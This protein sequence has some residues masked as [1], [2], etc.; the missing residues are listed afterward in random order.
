MKRI[1]SDAILFN[2][3]PSPTEREAERADYVLQRLGEFGYQD[4]AL[5]EFGNVTVVVPAR[6]DTDEH[7]LMFSDIRCEDYSPVESMT[8]LETDRVRGKGIAESSVA[9]AALLVLGEYLVRNEIQYD[10]NVVLLFT[11]FDPGERE[12]QP[13]E[14]F[15]QGWKARLRSAAHVRGLELGRV[16][17]RPLGTCKLSVKV[18][19]EERPVAAGQPAPSAIWVLASI[20]SRLGSIR[21]DAENSTFLNVSRLEAGVG[22]GWY[23]S[24]GVLELE[25]FSP[26]PATLDVARKAVEATIASVAQETGA[27]VD[28]SVK[29]FLPAGDSGI[30]QGLATV[31]R[32]IYERLH[33]KPRPVSLPG[34]ASL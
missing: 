21:W 25:V 18:H 13:L 19:T 1:V 2:E 14:Q 5:D 34:Y 15:L 23:P 26:S 10:R 7:V 3:I 11:S 28:T 31:V 8:K 22:F 33:I 12:T 9:T 27:T 24:E 30:N 17:D 32:E 6:E 20:A 16:E 4:A 29:A